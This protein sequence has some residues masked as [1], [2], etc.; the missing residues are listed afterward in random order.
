MVAMV[1][2]GIQCSLWSLS[3]IMQENIFQNKNKPLKRVLRLVVSKKKQQ[4]D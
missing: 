2:K 1:A 3:I 4:E